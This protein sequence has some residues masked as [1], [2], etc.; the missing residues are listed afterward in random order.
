[1]RT[2]ANVVA[3]SSFALLV[4]AALLLAI[5]S[6]PAKR[7]SDFD[8]SFYLTIAYDL[9]RHGV[10]SN[11]VFDDVDSTVAKPSAGMFFAPV[12]P[13]LVLAA[14]K[15]DRRFAAAVECAVESNHGR[16]DSAGCDIYARPIHVMH[17]LFLTLGIIAIGFAAELIIAHR[18]AFLVAG[19]LAAIGLALEAEPFSYIMTESVTFSL[20]S[21]LALSLAAAWK[22]G[23]RRYFAVAG[24]LLGLLGLTRPSYVVLAIAIPTLYM[25]SRRLVTPERQRSVA[26]Q[27]LAFGVSFSVVLAPWALRNAL[28]VGKLGLTEEYG[29][30]SLVERFAYDE[31]TTG[32]FLLAF[33]YC[34]PEIGPRAIGALFGPQTMARFDWREPAGFFRHGRA[35]R[36]ALIRVHGRLDPIIG[37]LMRAEWRQNGWRYLAVTLPLAWCGLWVAQIWSLFLLPIFAVLG[38]QAARRSKPLLLLYAAPAIVMV[39]VHA[40]VANH[41]TRYN[42]GLIGPMSIAGA[43]TA[44]WVASTLGRRGYAAMQKLQV[45]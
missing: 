41:Y 26:A 34:L 15:L 42:L 10:F 28:L 13:W 44:L 17:A 31:M 7:L 1:M 9:D 40:A 18:L 38:A 35:Q 37:D 5:A 6:R 11:G 20:Y 33:P 8:Q 14:T 16:R 25:I 39:G 36:V 24:L 32:E 23:K 43:W 30:A 45:L 27:L 2:S 3:T 19:L 21:L 22:R 12:Y 29:S 4:F